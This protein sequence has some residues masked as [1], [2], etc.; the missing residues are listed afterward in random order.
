MNAGQKVILG[1]RTAEV[2]K[3]RKTAPVAVVRFG[4]GSTDLHWFGAEPSAPAQDL[5]PAPKT[6]SEGS[7]G[8]DTQHVAEVVPIR[9]G[10]EEPSVTCG[11]C[12]KSWTGHRPE[13]CTVCHETF[14]GTWTG[15][16]HRVGSYSDPG[17]PRRCLDPAEAG[18]RLTSR[19]LWARPLDRDTLPAE[20]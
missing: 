19:G 14:G 15:D 20:R 18:L 2:I 7:P 1:G 4:D 8:T 12:R 13:H 16:K 9:S 5:H 17:D 3:V 6:R 10:D 11:V